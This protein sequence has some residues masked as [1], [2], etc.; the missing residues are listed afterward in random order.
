MDNAIKELIQYGAIGAI[1]VFL[2]ISLWYRDKSHT[3]ERQ[4]WRESIDQQFKH[5]NEL[6][7][8]VIDVTSEMKGIIQS[9]KMWKGNGQ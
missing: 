2:M 8:K 6:S 9:M 1:C 5:S 3:K 7:Q 4:E